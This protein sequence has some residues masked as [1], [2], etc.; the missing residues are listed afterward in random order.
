LVKSANK[1]LVLIDNYV[2]E[3]LHNLFLKREDNVD[4]KIYTSNLTASLKSDLEKHNKQYPP[5][6]IKVY[7]NAHDRFLIIDEKH[8]YHIGASLKD[9]GKKLFGFSKME[10]EANLLMKILTE[11]NE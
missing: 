8:V 5:I 1:S 4:V 2:D 10:I 6:E 3:S 11:K 9:L 7:K